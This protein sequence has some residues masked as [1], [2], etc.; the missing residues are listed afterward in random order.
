M[1]VLVCLGWY[2]MVTGQSVVLWSRLH[3]IVHHPRQIRWVLYMIITSFFVF[4]VPVTILFLGSNAGQNH[5]VGPFNVYEKIQLA[6]FSTQ[7]TIISG[8]YIWHASRAL[9]PIMARKARDGRNVMIHLVLV[10]VIVII[11]DCS[12]LATEY[13]N[14]FEIQTTYKTVVYSVKLKMEFS[15]IN[16]LTCLVM[17]ND[18]ENPIP[19]P[20][21]LPCDGFDPVDGEIADG[22]RSSCISQ[23][24][25]DQNRP[26]IRLSLPIRASECFSSS[27]SNKLS[28][29]G[30]ESFMTGAIKRPEK[31]HPR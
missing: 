29:S 14:N 5:F 13:T 17:N 7:E 6:G 15:V 27:A 10:N 3:L 26:T 4:H 16:R 11:M 18:S 2:G 8:L 20:S 31:S 12:L 22:R 28:I 9:K 1:S 19:P 21:I 25:N 24:D 30:D 23:L